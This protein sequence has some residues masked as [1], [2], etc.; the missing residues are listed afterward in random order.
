MAMTKSKNSTFMLRIC[1]RSMILVRT[2][3][4]QDR[5]TMEF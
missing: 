1:G 3:F 2:I 5:V 4:F